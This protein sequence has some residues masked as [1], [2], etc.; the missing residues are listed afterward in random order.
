MNVQYRP[1][2][3]SKQNSIM[4]G[5]NVKKYKKTLNVFFKNK[6]NKV[7]QC[8]QPSRGVIPVTKSPQ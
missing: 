1:Q 2:S 8:L 3:T 6:K 7:T 4:E 5:H